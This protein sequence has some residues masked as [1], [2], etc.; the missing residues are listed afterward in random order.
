MPGVNKKIILQAENLITLGVHT[1]VLLVGEDNDIYPLNIYI[2][3]RKFKA[4]K[5]NQIFN[6]IKRQYILSIA[7]RDL[8][9]SKDHNDIILLRY[10]Y[11]I[12]S[13]IWIL[14]KIDKKCKVV[15]E[16]NTIEI[17]EWRLLG[18]YIG[19]LYIM[20]E[21]TFGCLCRSY[22]DGIIGVTDEI[23]SYELER[24]RIINMPYITIGNGIDVYRTRIR[25]PPSLVDEELIL[26]C[27]AS[28][29]RWHG[30]DRLL[31]GLSHYKGSI[32]VRLYMVGNGPEIPNL[33]LIVK[34]L[35]LADNVIFTDILGGSLLD[36]IFDKSHI[37]IGSLG[38]HRM[39]M[40][41]ASI[42]KAREYCAR[43]IPFLYECSD[44]D[45][46]DNFPYIKIVSGDESPIEI[47]EV[48]RFAKEVYLDPEH[49]IKMRAYAEENLDWSVKM[50]MLKEFCEM[51]VEE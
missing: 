32:K 9:K 8:I 31:R 29:S 26:L 22:T 13:P 36:D 1:E 37:A 33:R 39:N 15:T 3:T 11:P 46:P 30:I 7:F 23:T 40:K 6:I 27:V 2:K 10:P 21:L 16:H 17:K 47:E 51:L 49:H 48:I 42:L 5:L 34:E 18:N 43:G 50:K 28:F 4:S 14:L 45:F 38:L 20:W 12:F 41:E 19:F 25:K 24:S 44:P 35:S